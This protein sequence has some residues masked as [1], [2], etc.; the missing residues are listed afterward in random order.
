MKTIKFLLDLASENCNYICCLLD[1][2]Y[3]LNVNSHV[4]T[5]FACL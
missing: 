5:I 4:V 2:E 3:E 1:T